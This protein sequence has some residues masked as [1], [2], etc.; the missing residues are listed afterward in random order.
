M[1]ARP[2]A[3][4]IRQPLGPKGHIEASQLVP[5]SDIV[6]PQPNGGAPRVPTERLKDP[7]R[8]SLELSVKVKPRHA[9]ATSQASMSDDHMGPGPSP[10]GRLCNRN[11]PIG[12]SGILVTRE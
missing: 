2:S 8:S 11:E 10:E 6:Y 12:E 9:F 1:P 7:F 5:E 4:T 3:G